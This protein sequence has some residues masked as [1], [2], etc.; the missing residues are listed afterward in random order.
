VLHHKEEVERG[1]KRKLI[2][3][4]VI[5]FPRFILSSLFV[6]LDINIM[7]IFFI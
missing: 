7:Y 3:S 6:P 2:A 4:Q 5:G 1:A